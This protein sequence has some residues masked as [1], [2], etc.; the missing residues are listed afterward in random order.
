MAVL[1]GTGNTKGL[2]VNTFLAFT[3]VLAG[4]PASTLNLLYYCMLNARC[5]R[6]FIS[7]S[8]RKACQITCLH[9]FAF[10]LFSSRNSEEETRR[11]CNVR[12]Q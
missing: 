8:Q 10:T 7:P 4:K 12:A 6:K 11:N 3:E 5:T 9:S 1:S 2:L